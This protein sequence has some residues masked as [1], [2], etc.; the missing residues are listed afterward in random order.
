MLHQI[1]ITGDL[2]KDRE[3][4]LLGM[5]AFAVLAVTGL[6]TLSLMLL[7]RSRKKSAAP[8][9]DSAPAAIPTQAARETEPPAA[10]PVPEAS[11]DKPSTVEQEH[12]K[13]PEPAPN[14]QPVPKPEPKSE[15]IPEPKPTAEEKPVIRPQAKE[16]SPEEKLEEIRRRL[17]EIRKNPHPDPAPILPKI[18]PK[19]PEP[20]PEPEEVKEPKKED[21][22]IPFD[23]H[24]P[25]TPEEIDE[26]AVEE[27]FSVTEAAA[28]GAI[29]QPEEPVENPTVET[30]HSAEEKSR[31]IAA[32]PLINKNLPMK[33][34]TFAE[35]VELFKQPG[36]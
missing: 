27:D 2:E 7:R 13:R 21:F 15:P 25:A 1:E 10:M 18:E 5:G 4:F 34:L 23:E 9:E 29:A 33:K 26:T 35:W 12:V 28:E 19:K 30:G 22:Y 32:D 3:I 24:E 16:T 6:I 14:I 36:A 31:E 11:Q 20:K 17:E 8:A